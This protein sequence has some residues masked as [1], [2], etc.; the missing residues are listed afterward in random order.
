M[1]PGDLPTCKI[2]TTQGGVSPATRQTAL[3]SPSMI[4]TL[5]TPWLELDMYASGAAPA[6]E[7][8]LSSNASRPSNIPETRLVPE[9]LLGSGQLVFMPLSQ[10]SDDARRK[11]RVR[12]GAYTR[13]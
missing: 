4:D 11:T 13:T 1:P 5:P 12:F 3:G 9:N 8:M 7:A 6:T 2:F 10:C